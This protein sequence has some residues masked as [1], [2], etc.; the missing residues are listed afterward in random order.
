MRVAL[1]AAA[2]AGVGAVVGAAVTLRFFNEATEGT[3][4]GETAP[5]PRKEREEGEKVGKGGDSGGSLVP[6]P[7]ARVLEELLKAARSAPAQQKTAVAEAVERMAC[8]VA[9][10]SDP[11][12]APDVLVQKDALFFKQDVTFAVD[13]LMDTCVGSMSTPLYIEEMNGLKKKL[14][15]HV[16]AM[17][18]QVLERSRERL[19]KMRSGGGGAAES[20]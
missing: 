3:N 2:G 11:K 16:G 14:L 15:G 5:K 10:V 13:E 12:W 17:S 4:P 9:E 19:V 7:T 20:L 6:K 8:L 1:G 18:Q